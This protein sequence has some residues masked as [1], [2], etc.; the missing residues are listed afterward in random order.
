[1]H[2]PLAARGIGARGRAMSDGPS[3]LQSA[4]A[5]LARVLSCVRPSS[6]QVESAREREAPRRSESEYSERE[7]R[8]RERE[9]QILMATWM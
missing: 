4:A 8:E 6:G 9:I 3:L 7:T 2:P 5:R 1:M